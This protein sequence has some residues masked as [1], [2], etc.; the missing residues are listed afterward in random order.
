MRLP[1]AIRAP[2]N[3]FFELRDQNCSVLL[4]NRRAEGYLQC[5]FLIGFRSGRVMQWILAIP[6]R[7]YVDSIFRLLR[8]KCVILTIFPTQDCSMIE[9]NG[10]PAGGQRRKPLCASDETHIG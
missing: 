10:S 1:P 5:S 3:S 9:I 8:G 2:S 4:K 6:V 7:G